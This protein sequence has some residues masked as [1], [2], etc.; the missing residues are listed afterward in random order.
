VLS[1]YVI[2]YG[3]FEIPAGALGD[4]NGQRL[5]LTRI[6]A[7]WS[8]FTALTAWCTSFTQLVGVRFLFGVGAAGAYPNA[9]GVMSRWLPAKERARGQGV[10]WGASRLGGALA[11]LTLVPIAGAFGW[12]SVFVLLAILGAVW[13]VI[14]WWWYRDRPVQ[15]AGISAQELAEIGGSQR[16]GG[17]HQAP[18]WGSCCGSSSSGSSFWPMVLC[19]GSWFY[20]NWFPTWMVSAA[21]FSTREMGVYASFPFLLGTVSQSRRR[22][23]LRPAGHPAWNSSGLSDHHVH[24]SAA[25]SVLL[26]GMTTVSSQVA[27]VVLASVS[28]AIMDLMLP[29]A[30]P[31]VCASVGR[32]AVSR[33]A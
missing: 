23:A 9:S 7:W 1:A 18:P 29:A 21:H 11:P 22:L 3:L 13:S 4:R 17:T 30:W 33:R 12:R 24:L 31:C 28:F 32:T 26:F 10:V 2:A 20:F 15:I 25:T 5:E 19:L 27:I 8:V 6:S 16:E 14:W